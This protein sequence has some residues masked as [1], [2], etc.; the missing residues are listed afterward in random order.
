MWQLRRTERIAALTMTIVECDS[1]DT[2][3]IIRGFLAVAET[4]ARLHG[5]QVRCG[6]SCDARDFADRIEQL[7]PVKGFAP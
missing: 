4:M 1:R 5:E 2:R 6:I 3:A 7:I